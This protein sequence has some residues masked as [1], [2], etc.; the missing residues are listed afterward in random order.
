VSSA[1]TKLRWEFQWWWHC[2]PSWKR[3]SWNGFFSTTFEKIQQSVLLD[4]QQILL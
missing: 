3:V 1:A 2:L 4:C